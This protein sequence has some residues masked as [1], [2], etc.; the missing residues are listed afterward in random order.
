MRVIV[1]GGAGFIGKNLV[2]T[3]VAQNF[4][5]VCCDIVDTFS[6]EYVKYYQVKE[7]REYNDIIQENDIVIY[8]KWNGVPVSSLDAEGI[9]LKD[10]IIDLLTVLD[11]CSKKKVAKFI[12]SSSGGSVYGKP[13]Y[14]PI[15]EKHKLMP[16]SSYSIQKVSAE[17]YIKMI[18][19]KNN[20]DYNILRIS[21]P[22]GPGQKP[23]TGQ[24]IISTYLACSLQDRT[25]QFRGDG[26]DIRDYIYI[27]D[28]V[29][30]I[31][32]TF[33]Y[34]G[35][36]RIFNIGSGTGYT[37]N[38]L[39]SEIDKIL[40]GRSM[41][42]VKKEY[43]PVHPSDVNINVLDCTLAKNEL[44]WKCEFVLSDGINSMLDSWNSS[45][46]VFEVFNHM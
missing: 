10:N 23:F 13:E 41:Q 18:C 22:F 2:K 24:G 45:T 44:R 9:T 15:D 16:I 5:V 38:K 3:L 7:Q 8:L 39:T 40:I 37:L 1:I 11:I 6:I 29:I 4:E 14:L 12:F 36:E 32:K 33:G 31:I 28:L 19:E 46:G 25:F 20:L 21:N 27:D 42:A 43:I 34:H 30:A 26:C 17:F 35:N